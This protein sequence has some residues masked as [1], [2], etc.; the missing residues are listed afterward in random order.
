MS[1]AQKTE[2]HGV[3]PAQLARSRGTYASENA[4]ELAAERSMRRRDQVLKLLPAKR[5]RGAPRHG[6]N[7]HR[8]SPPDSAMVVVTRARQRT[9]RLS[10]RDDRGGQPEALQARRQ[11]D[12]EPV[13]HACR[14]RRDDDLVV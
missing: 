10:G 2:G 13:R 9:V 8:P 3:S 12:V 5:R 4:A 14:K 7:G 6:R 11:V 1:A